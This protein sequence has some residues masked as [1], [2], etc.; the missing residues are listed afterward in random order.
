M[1]TVLD[2][3]SESRPG[4]RA[5]A[6]ARIARRSHHRTPRHLQTAWRR[7]PRPSR[8]KAHRSRCVGYPLHEAD[9]RQ[10]RTGRS[11][12]RDRHI[13]RCGDRGARRL[14]AAR[15]A[16]C[17]T[18][19][20]LNGAVSPGSS[21]PRGLHRRR[22]NPGHSAR[23]PH[24]AG[25]HATPDPGP[26]RRRD[27][28]DRECHGRGPDREAHRP[29]GLT[30]TAA[31]ASRPPRRP[32]RRARALRQSVRRAPGRAL[33]CSWRRWIAP[34]D[35]LAT[36]RRVGREVDDHS[37]RIGLAVSIPQRNPRPGRRPGP[38]PCTRCARDT[39][40]TTAN[41]SCTPRRPTP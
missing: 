15:R 39:P 4:R 32:A 28:R 14:R 21:W 8:G 33:Q 11:S 37:P 35:R 34:Q 1:T 3:T 9:L 29:A 16:V 19:A 12:S 6:A 30:L 38:P 10:A 20:T 13:V 17:T 31:G 27:A 5:R 23:A 2:P 41:A 25:L 26:H 7:L 22:R 18:S 36:H 24:R 40:H